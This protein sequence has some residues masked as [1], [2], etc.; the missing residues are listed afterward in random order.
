MAYRK[1]LEELVKTYVTENYPAEAQTIAAES[2]GKS[3]SRIEYPRIKALAKV[4][5][6]IGNDETHLVK[7]N[8]DLSV[9]DMKN[10]IV[11]LSHLLVAERV[12]NEAVALITARQS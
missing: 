11:A 7:K 1:A 4:A 12:G 8:P 10:F 6:W 3:I 9:A 2:L 5:A